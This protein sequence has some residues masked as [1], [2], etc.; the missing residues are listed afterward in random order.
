MVAAGGI[1]ID[2]QSFLCT[3]VE[4]LTKFERYPFEKAEAKKDRFVDGLIGLVVGQSFRFG[5]VV[6]CFWQDCQLTRL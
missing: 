4:L 5:E 2:E 3:D 6:G 1:L